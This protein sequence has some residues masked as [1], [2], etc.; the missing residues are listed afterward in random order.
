MKYTTESYKYLFD[1]I[2]DGDCFATYQKKWYYLL[3]KIISFI[4]GEK[5]S[6]AISIFNVVEGDNFVKFTIAE[7]IFPEK[8]WETCV[9]IK[10]K[11]NGV[12]W[13]EAVGS[14]FNNKY[15][16]LYHV[17]LDRELTDEQKKA[18]KKYHLKP[19]K[20]AFSEYAITQN[21]FAKIFANKN[22]TYSNV[23]AS[24]VFDGLKEVDIVD[25]K[26]DDT[27]PDPVELLKC[28][29]FKK[30]TKIAQ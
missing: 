4:S 5:V 16:D 17:E 23:C 2:K 25:N 20:Y 1:N 18:F 19:K 12:Y 7:M 11:S 13:Y 27:S 21:W 24:D 9:I 22:K 8:K 26:F 29:F 14:K 6:H 28:S 10:N 3:T 30:I 15:L